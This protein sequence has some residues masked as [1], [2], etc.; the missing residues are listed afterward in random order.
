MDSF[1]FVANS[2]I[3]SLACNLTILVK[4]IESRI[5]FDKV[6]HFLFL[7][8]LGGSDSPYIKYIYVPEFVYSELPV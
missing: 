6:G 7:F 1:A 5:G 4:G 2:F 8:S 3:L